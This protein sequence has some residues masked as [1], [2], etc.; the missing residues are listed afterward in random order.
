MTAGSPT[1]LLSRARRGNGAALGELLDQYRTYLKLLVRVQQG[2]MRK[3]D[4]SDMVQNVYL[5]AHKAFAQFNGTTEAELTAWLRQILARCLADAARKKQR[6]GKEG[7]A[8]AIGAQLDRSSHDWAA[9]L[10]SPRE[11]PSQSAERREG[12]VLLAQALEQLPA[13][14]REA[15]VLRQMEGLSSQEVAERMD[16]SVDSVR[17]L[18]ARGMIELRQILKAKT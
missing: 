7:I 18:W 2:G 15:I 11:S 12:A 10:V 4:P 14:Y 16:R 13:D 6:E 9:R 3:N 5:K 8:R 1:L 17:K